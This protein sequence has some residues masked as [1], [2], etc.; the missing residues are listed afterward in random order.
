MN[1]SRY[2]QRRRTTLTRANFSQSLR[3][4]SNVE[5][6]LDAYSAESIKKQLDEDNQ[7]A[8]KR[9]DSIMQVFAEKHRRLSVNSKMDAA[10]MGR[11]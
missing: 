9:R 1:A 4:G 6:K 2:D 11:V 3:K 7:L 10:L 8:V 5:L